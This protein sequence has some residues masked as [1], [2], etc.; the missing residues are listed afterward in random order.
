MLD[1]LMGTR[2][3]IQGY[4]LAD[5][6]SLPSRLKRLVDIASR[7]DFRLGW[8]IV[9]PNEIDSR[10]HK[11]KLPDRNF[12]R[13]GIGIFLGAANNLLSSWLV[14]IIGDSMDWHGRWL[15]GRHG[16]DCGTVKVH[17]D[18][19]AATNCV[20]EAYSQGRPFRVR[21]DIMGYD[22][23]VAGGIVRTPKGDSYA[24]SFDGDPAG[25]G[26]TSLFRQHLTATPCPRPVHLW[27]NPKGRINCFQQQLSPPAGITAPNFEPY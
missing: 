5:V 27:V 4:N 17:A 2:N 18:P 21:Y 15:M 20:L 26:G 22:S 14:P 7:F 9:T 11:N 25:Q 19:T 3:L 10:I 12:R 23:A 6:E 16:I 13:W 8:D 24:L 1:Q